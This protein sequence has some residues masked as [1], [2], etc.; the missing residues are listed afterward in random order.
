MVMYRIWIEG[1]QMTLKE[2]AEMI[3]VTREQLYRYHTNHQA[4]YG[5]IVRWW[6][7]GLVR[8]GPKRGMRPAVHMVDGRWMTDQEI[9]KMVRVNVQSIRNYCSTHQCLRAEAAQYYKEINAG[10]RKRY[11]GAKPL[12]HKVYGKWMTEYE[13][14]EKYRTKCGTLRAYRYKH[15]CSLDTA[16]RGLEARRQRRA[17]RDLMEILKEA[18]T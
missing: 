4:S 10:I 15:G 2:I 18:T 11:P 6:R 3:G 1:K 12:K 8:F 13:A 17:E 16:V 7:D 14:A 9:A 5:A